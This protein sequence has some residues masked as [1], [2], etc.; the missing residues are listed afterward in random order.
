[1]KTALIS[2][3]E[4]GHVPQMYLEAIRATGMELVC[5][6][7]TTREDLIDLARDADILWMFGVCKPLTA[8]VLNQLPKCRAIFRS[9]SGVD[10]LPWQCATEKNIA[11]CNSPESIAEAVAEH[12]AALLLALAK[13]IQLHD[14]AITSGGWLPVSEGTSW[15]LNG[16]TLGLVGY[17]RIARHVET[18]LSGFQLKSI[19]HD[20]FSPHSVPLDEL[21]QKADFI[22]LHC[23]LTNATRHLIAEKQFQQMKKNALLVNTSR[24]AV[25]KETALIDALE[26]GLIAG[27]ALDVTETEPLE[28]GSPLRK[29]PNVIITSHIAAF[30]NDFDKN[31]WQCSVEK[32]KELLKGDFK[33]NSLNLI[34]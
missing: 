22:S 29:L 14:R 7:C 27:A 2:A 31:F 24:G 6:N 28:S 5:R 34:P 21:L 25:I 23:P 10:E 32:L 13:K 18:M 15:H 4:P 12:A 30:T 11:I 17:G 33:G 26:K 8:E 20:P 19:H 3:N 9:G 1:M 16:R